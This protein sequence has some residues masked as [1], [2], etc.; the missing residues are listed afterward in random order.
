MTPE[1][2]TLDPTQFDLAAFNTARFLE[3]LDNVTS[4]VTGQNQMNPIETFV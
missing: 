1:I 3:F 2:L 4:V